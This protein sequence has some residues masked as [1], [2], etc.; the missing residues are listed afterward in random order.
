MRQIGWRAVPTDPGALGQIAREAMPVIMQ[1]FVARDSRDELTFERLLYLARRRIENAV[2]K[3][4]PGSDFYV[5]SLS[6]R[7]IVYK[8]LLIPV[9][10]P[11]FYRD[12]SDARVETAVALVHSRFSTNTFPTW[13][14]AHPYRMLCHNGE[15]NTLRGNINWMRVREGRVVQDEDTAF[16]RDIA[17]LMPVVMPGGSDSAA[18]DNALEF[19][20]L[21]GRSLPHAMAMLIPE[22]WSGDPE[23]TPDRKAFYE[24]HASLMEPWDGPAA[25][26]FCD[27]KHVGAMLD[28]NGLRP[29]RWCL[30]EDGRA[31]LASE[32]GALPIDAANVKAKGRLQPGMM[33]LV[34]MEE[35]RVIGDTELK[36]RLASARPYRAWVDAG[37]VTLESLPE[38]VDLSLGKLRKRALQLLLARQPANQSQPWP[39][40]WS[41]IEW[42]RQPTW[43]RSRRPARSWAWA[44]SA[45]RS[46]R[47][48]ARKS[49]KP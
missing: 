9:Q 14:R 32:A 43:P 18:L 49:S 40:C 4:I 5:V 15:I 7:T 2:E 30:T 3:A 10:I 39:P 23:M 28:R 20:V 22:A 36:T 6:S 42:I 24:Y 46:P 41:V 1:L 19:L 27:G 16:G 37:E 47:I 45:I 34:D 44:P 13:A 17:D 33:F 48:S 11:F 26:A 29:A 21:G 12:L 35:G 31:I 38:A 25:V 8:G